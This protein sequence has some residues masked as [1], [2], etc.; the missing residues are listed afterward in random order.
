VAVSEAQLDRIAALVRERAPFDVSPRGVG[1]R[2]DADLDRALDAVAAGGE[3]AVGP[4]EARLAGA[5]PLAALAWLTALR[6]IDA[7]AAR[8][9]VDAYAERVEREDPGPGGFPGA[10]EVLRFLGR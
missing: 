10:R 2:P 9:A 4:L 5:D 8:A 7:P 6:R 1:F 3:A